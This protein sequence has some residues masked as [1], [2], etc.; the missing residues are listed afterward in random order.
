[1]VFL[2]FF[3]ESLTFSADG[4]GLS[5]NKR[6]RLGN[7]QP[8]HEPAEFLLRKLPQLRFV[9]RP[10][11]PFLRQALV[12]Q[13]VSRSVPIQRFDAVCPPSAEQIQR[14]LIHFLAELG[15]HQCSQAVYLL[16]HVRIAA[17]DVVVLHAAEIKHGLSPSRTP[18][19]SRYSCPTETRLRRRA[20]ESRFPRRKTGKSR[21]QP[22]ACPVPL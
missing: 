14:R 18:R 6:F 4:S 13:N 22:P 9:S 15:L 2:T 17:G 12:Q 7:G 11:E 3:R 5:R 19:E 21:S 8:L 10:L 16:A 1:M 20:P